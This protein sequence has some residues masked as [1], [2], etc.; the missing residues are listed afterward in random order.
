MSHEELH[1]RRYGDLRKVRYSYLAFGYIL[2]KVRSIMSHGRVASEEGIVTFV[3][4][5]TLTLLFNKF[6]DGKVHHEPWK[7][8]I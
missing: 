8:C 4:L 6:C 7:S 3:R 2:W 5:G 1:L